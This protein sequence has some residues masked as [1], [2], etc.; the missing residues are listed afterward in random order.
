MVGDRK[1]SAEMELEDA[2]FNFP[3]KKVVPMRKS[4]QASPLEGSGSF[5]LK[6][7]QFNLLNLSTED[8]PDSTNP[9]P[10]DDSL[11]DIAFTTSPERRNGSNSSGN[12]PGTPTFLLRHNPEGSAF[13]LVESPGNS[14]HVNKVSLARD[15]FSLTPG[16]IFMP[17]NSKRDASYVGERS[18]SDLGNTYTCTTDDSYGYSGAFEHHVRFPTPLNK[19]H[20]YE[21]QNRENFINFGWQHEEESK[22]E[23]DDS[24]LQSPNLGL[25]FSPNTGSSYNYKNLTESPSSDVFSEV[26]PKSLFG[27]KEDFSSQPDIM[28]IVSQLVH[29]QLAPESFIKSYLSSS[30]SSYQDGAG[31][32][33]DHGEGEGEVEAKGSARSAAPRYD[34]D[35]RDLRTSESLFN[36]QR[37]DDRQKDITNRSAATATAINSAAVSQAWNMDINSGAISSDPFARGIQSIGAGGLDRGESDSPRG[38]QQNVPALNP[39]TSLLYPAH[40]MY[41]Q[42]EHH[43]QGLHG[44]TQHEAAYQSSFQQPRQQLN[45]QH[46][47]QLLL[48]QQQQIQTQHAGAPSLDSLGFSTPQIPSRHIQSS[49]QNVNQMS[50][51]SCIINQPAQP[52]QPMSGKTHS[53]AQG[54]NSD[55]GALHNS[56]AS[57]MLSMPH[58]QRDTDHPTVLLKH[59]AEPSFFPPNQLRPKTY[60]KATDIGQGINYLSQTRGCVHSND[61]ELDSDLG[62]RQLISSPRSGT[63]S[64]SGSG[65]WASSFSHPLPPSRSLGSTASSL[66]THNVSELDFPNPL[67][68]PIMS[69]SWSSA[70]GAGQLGCHTKNQPA[71]QQMPLSLSQDFSVPSNTNWS[72]NSTNTNRLPSQQ[73]QQQQQQHHQGSFAPFVYLPPPPV[74]SSQYHAPIGGQMM[75]VTGLPTAQYGQYVPQGPHT[76]AQQRHYTPVYPSLQYALDYRDL[77]Q[78]QQHMDDDRMLHEDDLSGRLGSMGLTSE[79]RFQFLDANSHRK[80]TK[81]FGQQNA[82]DVEAIMQSY[83]AT[84]AHKLLVSQNAINATASSSSFHNN[85]HAHCDFGGSSVSSLN[86][87]YGNR[88]Y[89]DA[90]QQQQQQQQQFNQ[91]LLPQMVERER[92]GFDRDFRSSRDLGSDSEKPYTESKQRERDSWD[93]QGSSLFDLHRGG[94]SDFSGQHASNISGLNARGEDLRN[95]SSSFGRGFGPLSQSQS[96]PPM[97]LQS[98]LQGGQVE[99]PLRLSMESRHSQS[100]EKGFQGHASIPVPSMLGR[101]PALSQHGDGPGSGNT[102]SAHPSNALSHSSSTAPLAAGLLTAPS[103]ASTSAVHVTSS[104]HPAPKERLELVESP[105]SKLAYKDFYRHFRGMERESVEVAKQYAEESLTW[106]PETAR[107]RVLL[108]LADLAK[109]SNDF[110]KVRLRR[111][112]LSVEQRDCPVLSSIVMPEWPRC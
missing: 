85:T 100:F 94:H 73:Q 58:L 101:G 32:R 20:R 81:S 27:N 49:G 57:Q 111:P 86:N 26:L 28:G 48:L 65:T 8:L 67:P 106:M 110:D 2:P 53:H 92:S 74:T 71:P 34:L 75:P 104:T 102:Y 40:S 6:H 30:S 35:P 93:S 89:L 98:R 7:K 37:P 43:T 22:R 64:T 4:L 29:S 9:G 51:G 55:N 44:L 16:L 69:Q 91:K 36:E 59:C 21:N 39:Q 63:T 70:F 83:P 47:L 38:G 19:M 1:D 88:Q 90:R 31:S 33:Q 42:Q 10:H 50:S 68:Q 12:S 25:D 23:G 24:S 45:Q 112:S 99:D 77:N 56:L 72:R 14:R 84:D 66:N 13:K 108:E 87:A 52:T 5:S 103:S 54:P 15:T 76:H 82:A 78:H 97:Q 11:N 60:M 96:Q 79:S 18:S 46:L 80:T 105:H 3:I 41:D 107:W 61:L 95:T 109:R 17:E 62:I